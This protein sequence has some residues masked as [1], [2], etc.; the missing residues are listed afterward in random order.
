MKKNDWTLVD[1]IHLKVNEKKN[2]K[3]FV[4]IE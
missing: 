3:K 4:V 2:K 1:G